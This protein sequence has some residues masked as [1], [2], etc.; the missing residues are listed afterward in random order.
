MK[1]AVSEH[2]P[3]ESS[4]WSEHR[5]GLITNGPKAGRYIAVQPAEHDEWDLQ[6]SRER[7]SQ[8]ISDAYQRIDEARLQT[9]F[10]EWDVRWLPVGIYADAV[11]QRFFRKA[12]MGEE[13]L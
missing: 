1:L 3:S 2:L 12:M 7:S 6:V 9:L 5:V 10:V 13:D 11:T 8:G 4:E